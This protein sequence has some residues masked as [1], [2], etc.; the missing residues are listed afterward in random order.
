MFKKKK[1]KPKG[2]WGSPYEMET[3]QYQMD[4]SMSYHMQEEM[5][6]HME[7]MPMPYHMEGQSPFDWG[8]PN[9]HHMGG[10]NPHYMG[11]MPYQMEKDMHHH[12]HHH[13]LKHETL[14]KV[15]KW[16]DYGMKEAKKTSYKHA[17]T[18]V[19][20][21]SYLL[22]KGVPPQMAYKMVESWETNEKFY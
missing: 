20:A 15:D 16:V 6:Y 18:E 14:M 22:G 19:A 9:P 17:M 11:Y 5:P 7:G 2:S 8:G 3:E 21:I 4:E 1:P 12:S 13:H 10:H